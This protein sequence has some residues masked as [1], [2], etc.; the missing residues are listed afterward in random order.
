MYPTIHVLT[1]HLH[2]GTLAIEAVKTFCSKEGAGMAKLINCSQRMQVI[3]FDSPEPPQKLVRHC[4]S[5]TSQQ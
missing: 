4:D 3:E 2:L 1:T 5:P